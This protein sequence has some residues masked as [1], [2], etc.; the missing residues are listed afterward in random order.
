L[1]CPTNKSTASPQVLPTSKLSLHLGVDFIKHLLCPPRP[2]TNPQTRPQLYAEL[3][4]IPFPV[5]VVIL[6]DK[7][8][9]TRRQEKEEEARVRLIKFERQKERDALLRVE[10]KKAAEKAE[11]EKLKA[12]EEKKR[13]EEEEKEKAELEL[14]EK[15][16]KEKIEKE[17]AEEEKRKDK[18]YNF[19]G[20]IE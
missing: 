6:P 20:R 19:Y 12:E 14:K 13:L 8:L 11:E 7:K 17:I 3:V 5:N 4:K 1:P 2:I 9:E 10:A 16:E 18:F 15:E